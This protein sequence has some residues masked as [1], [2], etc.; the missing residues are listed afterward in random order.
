MP[1]RN[2][3]HWIFV[4][5]HYCDWHYNQRDVLDAIDCVIK[6]C[7]WNVNIEHNKR[8]FI[9]WSYTVSKL[10]YTGKILPPFIFTLF[11]LW[12]EGELKTG[13]IDLLLCCVYACLP[14]ILIY[15]LAACLRSCCRR[16]HLFPVIKCPPLPLQMMWFPPSGDWKYMQVK[17]L[18]N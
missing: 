11:A 13:L 2:A 14:L 17:Y 1:E 18:L 6:A 15:S 12:P 16:V 3:V 7:G 9:Y 10:L 4:Q 8:I 5:Y